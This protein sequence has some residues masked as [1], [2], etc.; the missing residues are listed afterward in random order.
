MDQGKIGKFIS[1]CRKEVGLTQ[2]QLADKLGITD[3]AVSKWET[4]KSLPDSSIMLELCSLIN[5]NV[6]ELLT[7]ERIDMEN[8]KENAE[9][10]LIS[11]LHNRKRLFIIRLIGGFLIVCGIIIFL[12]FPAILEMT[13]MQEIVMRAMGILIFVCGNLV[14]YFSRKF[15]KGN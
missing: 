12:T 9:N 2:A 5:I 7:G 1:T 14:T 6:N 4:G 11:L 13:M 15:Q 3:R 8:Y 10:N